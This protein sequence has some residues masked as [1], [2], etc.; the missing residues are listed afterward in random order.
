MDVV[1]GCKQPLL[2]L[3]KKEYI[4]EQIDDLKA[5]EVMEVDVVGNGTD[6]KELLRKIENLEDEQ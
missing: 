4:R 6:V 5:Q 2:L 1:L 3:L